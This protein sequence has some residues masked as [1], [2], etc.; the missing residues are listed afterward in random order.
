MR[1][2]AMRNENKL[3][4]RENFL[5]SVI[6]KLINEYNSLRASLLG[7]KLFK[8][9]AINTI[10]PIPGETEFAVKVSNKNCVLELT[11]ENLIRDYNLS[12]FSD[13]HADLIRQAAQGKLIQFLKCHDS[14][15][16][17][18]IASRKLD[19]E[20]KE[21]VFVI[22]NKDKQHFPRTAV[23]LSSEKD[24]LMN[25]DWHDVYD[26]GFTQGME[27]IIK[28]KCAITLAKNA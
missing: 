24:I 19:R 3:N 4:P 12:D 22:E 7:K 11:A 9:V 1:A 28:E 27:S 23:E 2:V 5:L 20:S 8:I 15:P 16:L 17:Y 13:Y 6:Y 25:L 10:S 21:Y 18:R 26:V 14:E